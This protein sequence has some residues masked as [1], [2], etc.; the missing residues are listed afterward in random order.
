M[1]SA[2]RQTFDDKTTSTSRIPRTTSCTEH[3]PQDGR[4]DH[5]CGP[6]RGLE[7]HR[8]HVL[9]RLRRFRARSRGRF[10]VGGG[11][12]CVW[13]HAA[14]DPTLG[15]RKRARPSILPTWNHLLRETGARKG[16][17]CVRQKRRKRAWSAQSH[18]S[19]IDFSPPIVNSCFLGYMM[20]PCKERTGWMGVPGPHG[21][22][23]R[24]TKKKSEK[25]ID[26]RKIEEAATPCA[27][28][29]GYPIDV[30]EPKLPPSLE[31]R[32]RN[33]DEYI[34]SSRPTKQSK[35]KQTGKIG[36]PVQNHCQRC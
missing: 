6:R 3:C 14:C 11:W 9:R 1:I 25:Q 26:T 13:R 27:C 32:K 23:G 21:E 34:R 20:S 17:R 33:I 8:R 16:L 36:R 31:G 12:R 28:S 4:R 35:I 7:D 15:E 19:S 29:H 30:M 2:A 18:E 22:G 10:G 5:H 24:E